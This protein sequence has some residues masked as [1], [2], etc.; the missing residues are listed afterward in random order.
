M[1]VEQTRGEK[2]KLPGDTNNGNHD[3]AAW[4]DYGNEWNHFGSFFVGF[5][6]VVIDALKSIKSH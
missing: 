5:V 6:V 1:G 2:M 4:R 3:P